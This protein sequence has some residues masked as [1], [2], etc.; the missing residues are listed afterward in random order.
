M[1]KGFSIRLTAKFVFKFSCFFLRVFGKNNLVQKLLTFF[2]FGTWKNAR[3]VIILVQNLLEEHYRQDN[4]FI[5]FETFVGLLFCAPIENGEKT[6]Q[7]YFGRSCGPRFRNFSIINWWHFFSMNLPN[8][9]NY[10]KSNVSSRSKDKSI[11]VHQTH[12]NLEFCFLRFTIMW[13]MSWTK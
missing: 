8:A 9:S 12:Q 7:F 6:T 5:H 1:L 11:F 3:F 13:H 4:L 2:F 10:K